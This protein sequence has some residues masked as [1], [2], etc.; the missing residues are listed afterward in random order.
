MATQANNKR[1]TAKQQEAKKKRK[2]IIFAVEILIILIMIAVLWLVMEK[3]PEGPS[4]TVLDPEELEI[5][6]DVQLAREEGGTM[7]GYV[8]IALFGVDAEKESQ[9]YKGSR[10][11]SIMI[12]SVNMDT[13]EIKLVS[14]YRDTYL[15]IGSEYRKCNAAY[16]FGGAEQAVKMLNMN[17][18]MDIEHFITVGYKGL[19]EVIDG[20][21]GVWIEVDS[22]ELRHINNYQ[23]GIADTLKCDYIPVSETG[24]QL[25][26]GIQATAYCR[27]RY[28]SGDDFKR[29]ARQREVIQA[30][31]DQA[32][33]ADLATLTKVFN[34]AIDDIYTNV[35]VDTIMTFLEKIA[36]YE[37]VDEG[38]F[39]QESMRTVANI[40][41]KGSSVIPLDLES[42][43]VWL[44]Q[45]LFDDA[46]YT[47]TDSVREYSQK[48]A[49]E[50]AAYIN[51]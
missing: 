8:N 35:D 20:L 29:T 7:H 34:S 9:L 27:I 37:I 26:N 22:E 45:F 36:T 15:N 42:N 39:P 43:V 31:E 18:D 21:G 40:G 32:K 50:T 25:L 41:A 51:K 1:V 49:S 14:V 12:A 48:I 10:S 44:H 23:I 33:Q 17:L 16:S 5:H 4:V 2:V 46:D 6:E 47:V 11:D 13:G 30:I 3:T 19:S 28:T 38:G 24:Y